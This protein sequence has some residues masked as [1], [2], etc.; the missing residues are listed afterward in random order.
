M[1]NGI[2][3]DKKEAQILSNENARL[4]GLLAKINALN[5]LYKKNEN[6]VG[7][8]SLILPDKDDKANLTAAFES[9]ASANGLIIGKIIFSEPAEKE[10]RA[11]EELKELKNDYETKTVELNLQG[12]YPSFKS[13]L[14][15]LENNLRAMDISS[16][17]F[18]S[19]SSASDASPQSAP[20]IFN[21]K[22]ETY[23]AKPI[24][25]SN[26]LGDVPGSDIIDPSFVKEKKFNDLISL[27]DYPVKVNKAADLNSKNIFA[28]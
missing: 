27:P 7:K 13:F 1:L 17:G 11:G 20:Y 25:E 26:L 2:R 10:A 22:L 14:K 21:L 5:S 18:A 9:L 3:E 16:V 19:S 4:N 8:F 6:S 15:T 23:L 24:D 12:S 28:P